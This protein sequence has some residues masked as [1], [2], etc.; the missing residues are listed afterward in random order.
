MGL[1]VGL[2]AMAGFAAGYVPLHD[3]YVEVRTELALCRAERERCARERA[4]CR[5]K[6]ERIAAL[7]SRLGDGKL[8][9]GDVLKSILEVLK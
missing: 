6:Q 8:K 7:L 1:M 5:E 4:G 2:A 9:K 3:R